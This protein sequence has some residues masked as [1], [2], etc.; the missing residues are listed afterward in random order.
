MSLLYR[1]IHVLTW[2]CF[3]LFYDAHVIG[4]EHLPKNSGCLI[5]SNHVSF[6]DAPLIGCQIPYEMYFLPR[7]TLFLSR[8]SGWI[9]P[10]LNAIPV[11]LDKPYVGALKKII[12]ILRSG[13]IVLLF[14]EGT[15][16][17][18][19][20]L[21]SSEP[22]VGFIIEKAGVPVVPLRIFGAYEAWPRDKCPKIFMPLQIVCGPPIIFHDLPEDAREKFVVMGDQ[23]MQAIAKLQPDSSLFH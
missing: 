20:K 1:I 14:P 11:E 23:V 9:L 5:V 3:R 19:G 18:D 7:K 22:G 15:R 21:Q 8:I 10:R 4:L 13:N 17:Y 6:L 12:Q 16:S 2:A